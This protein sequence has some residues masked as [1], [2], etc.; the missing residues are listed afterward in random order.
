MSNQT[1]KELDFDIDLL[2]FDD[3][4]EEEHE[5][6]EDDYE[7]ELPEEP[8]T[9]LGFSGFATWGIASGSRK[10]SSIICPAEYLFLTFGGLI[11]ALPSFGGLTGRAFVLAFSA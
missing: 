8:K 10:T 6:V 5:T 3:I 11:G 9:K 1:Q 7:V 4:G 2:G